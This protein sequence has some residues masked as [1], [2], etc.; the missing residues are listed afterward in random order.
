MGWTVLAETRHGSHVDGGLEKD[1]GGRRAP[2][3]RGSQADPDRVCSSEG[4]P[5]RKDRGAA[6]P[7]PALIFALLQSPA[8][9]L[10]EE[11]Q[12]DGACSSGVRLALCYGC[13]VWTREEEEGC[14]HRR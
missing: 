9:A 8:Q 10:R 3:A 6:V 12:G 1:A 11:A 4:P 7:A 2:Q 14:D 5:A 13:L